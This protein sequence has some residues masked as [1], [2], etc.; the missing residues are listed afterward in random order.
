MNV[1]ERFLRDTGSGSL[2]LVREFDRIERRTP[3]QLRRNV[4]TLGRA[5][6]ESGVT[7][8]DSIVILCGSCIEAIE[9]ILAS[10]SIGA[11]AVPLNL[12]SGANHIVSVIGRIQ[13]RACVFDELPDP[14]IVRALESHVH[15]CAAM[16]EHHVSSVQGCRTHASLLEDGRNDIEYADVSPQHRALILFSSG[17]QGSPKGIV[18]SQDDVAMFFDYHDFVFAQ[19]TDTADPVDAHAALVT[20]V[21]P[22]HL[23]GIAMCLQGLLNG[24]P[25]YL[26]RRFIPEL[27]LRMMERARCSFIML[28]P[29]LYRLVLREPH[30]RQMDTS[31]LRFC[32]TGGE[33]CSV[34]LARRIEAAFGAPAVTGYSMSECMSGIGHRREELVRGGIAHTSC[35]KL[36]FGEAKLIDAN[37]AEHPSTGE[38]WVRNRTVRACYLDPSMNQARLSE[39]WFRTGDLFYRDPQGNYFHQGRSDDMF[40]YN[41]KNI[42]PAEIES[43][44]MRHS[45]VEATFATAVYDGEGRAYPAALVVSNRE[46]T[47]AELIE[48][49][50]RNGPSHAIPRLLCFTDSLPQLGAG[51]VDR[52]SASRLLQNSFEAARAQK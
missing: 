52:P 9:W 38:L 28:V 19:Y 4:S 44:L 26:L 21:P 24:R 43:L 27:F 1:A 36:L 16:H 46:A 40:I 35:G 25:T 20:A 48:F 11:T 39:G 45:A 18:M 49:A 6:V 47:D 30:L 29:S 8:D 3:Q 51:K 33:P 14:A 42:Y 41:G 7:R 13:P 34:E 5:L 10:L 32:I 37:G 31:A 50:A 12:L 2:N 15:L 17:S 23:A 22:F